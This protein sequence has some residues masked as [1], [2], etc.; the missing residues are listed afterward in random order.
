[1]HSDN[2]LGHRSKLKYSTSA[3]SV[4]AGRLINCPMSRMALTQEEML[5]WYDVVPSFALLA[6][7][8]LTRV[9]KVGPQLITSIFR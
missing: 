3:A 6:K 2:V 5:I 7:I 1:M 9:I 4:T 8:F